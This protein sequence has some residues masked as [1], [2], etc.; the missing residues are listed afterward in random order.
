MKSLIS[1]FIVLFTTGFVCLQTTKSAVNWSALVG[2]WECEKVIWVNGKDS[3][4]DSKQYKP[5]FNNFYADLKCK[6]EYPA[7]YTTVEGKYKVD[8]AKN[9]ISFA[10]MVHTVKYPWA[11]T[12]TPDLVFKTGKKELFVVK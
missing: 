6:D 10:G 12:P 5:Y 11:K 4:D 3:T 2:K 9:R 1:I 8:K 7:G